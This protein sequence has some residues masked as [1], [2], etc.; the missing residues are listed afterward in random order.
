MKKIFE[1]PVK[2]LSVGGTTNELSGVLRGY[3]DTNV[4]CVRVE[5]TINDDQAFWD[6][7]SPA[8]KAALVKEAMSSENVINVLAQNDLLHL[9]G[10]VEHVDGNT[11]CVGLFVDRAKNAQEASQDAWGVPEWGCII[12]GV[13]VACGAL[14]AFSAKLRN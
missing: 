13:L 8:L 7:L 9:V 12:G 10:K 1:S 4:E 11:Y 3:D 5:M 2:F 14:Y 6:S